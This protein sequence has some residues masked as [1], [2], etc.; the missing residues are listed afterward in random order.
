MKKILSYLFPIRLN[1]YETSH[2]GKL[3][4]T[5]LDGRKILDTAIS[6]YSYGSLQRILYKALKKLPFDTQ[7]KEI[8]VLG[9]GAGSIIQTIREK[10]H[11][12]AQIT[13]VEF[14]KDIITIAQK[15]F[16]LNT[17]ANITVIHADAVDFMQVNTKTFDLVIVD[18]FII[19]SIPIAF[20]HTDFLQQL[21]AAMHTGGRLVFNTIRETL[22]PNILHQMS[23]ALEGFG[24]KVHILRKLEGSNDVI[25]GIK[26]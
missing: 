4:V 8:L 12:D 15:E 13:L 16:A 2:N 9:M 1:T 23:I 11:S 5:L 22:Q 7:A 21:S 25:L 14:D 18:L 10:F 26:P 6:N 17:F 20:T 3:S 24:L 19:D